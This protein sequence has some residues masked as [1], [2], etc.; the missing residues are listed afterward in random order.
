VFAALLLMGAAPAPYPAHPSTSPGITA[1][2][3]AARDKA[4]ADD[5][6]EGRGPGTVNGEASAQW[7]ADEL[8][9]LGVQPGNHGSYF[10]DVGAA[11]IALDAPKSSLS[12]ATSKG[13]LTPNFPEAV[14]YWTSQYASGTVDV[15]NSPLVFVGYGV[16]AP[17]YGWNDYAG[18]DVKGKTVVILVNDPGNED[19]APDPAFFKGKAMTYYG[20]WTYKFEEAARQGAAAAIIVHETI[21]AAYG[22]GVVRNSNSGNKY[23]LETPDQNGS[24]AKLEGWITL[25][26]AKDL[27]ARAGLDYAALKA[28]AN[29]R[30]FKAVAMN[31]ETL[32]A[33]AVSNISH[34]KTR[35]VIGVIPGKSHP[36]DVVMFSAHWDHLGI[37]PQLPGPDKIYNGAVDNG[38]G[39]S[40]ILELAEA[41]AHDA[42]PDRSVAFAFWTMEEQNLLGSEYFAE[43]PIWPLKNIVGVVNWDAGI[44]GGPAHDMGL[45]GNGQSEMEDVLAAALKTQNRVISPDPEPE[46]GGFFRSDHFSLARNGVPAITPSSGE[47]LVNGGKARAKALRDDYL[48]HHYHQPADEFDPSWDFSGL[49]QDTEVLHTLGLS[50]ANSGQWPNWFAAS[51]FRAARDKVMK[52]K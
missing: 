52:A 44:A 39:V 27:F 51:E 40:M 48:A 38:Y 25:D 47:D 13:A 15:K 41:F 29:K 5:A 35:N 31:G 43:H 9:R 49:V 3:I 12:F 7:I 8:K 32:S 14:T 2:D 1:A 50:L 17:E 19:A 37:K 33:H 22:W 23:W 4:I 21:P 6:F 36:G 24:R 28:A 42:Q 30:G 10:Q 16:V 26:T 20:R 11:V 18:V 45:T 46:K 34:V